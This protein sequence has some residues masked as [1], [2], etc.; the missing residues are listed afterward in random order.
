MAREES[1]AVSFSGTGN[2]RL[3]GNLDAAV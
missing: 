1:V 2:L 3:M